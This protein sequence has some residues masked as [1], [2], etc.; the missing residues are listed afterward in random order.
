MCSTFSFTSA[1]QRSEILISKKQI[2]LINYLIFV[3]V[4]LVWAAGASLSSSQ[5]FYF[6]SDVFLHGDATSRVVVVPVVGK[7]ALIHFFSNSEAG[8]HFT[9]TF[10]TTN[11]C[12][13]GYVVDRAG[14]SCIVCT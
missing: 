9:A 10:N 3:F 1:L 5:T 4:S 12:P 8:P 2:L 13:A 11:I 14:G 6:S 7:N